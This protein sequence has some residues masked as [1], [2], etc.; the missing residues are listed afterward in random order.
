MKTFAFFLQH[1]FFIFGSI[2]WYY[3]PTHFQTS[4]FFIF[5][6]MFCYKKIVTINIIII[7]IVYVIAIIFIHEIVIVIAHVTTVV[8]GQ[9]RHFLAK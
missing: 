5:D 4:I 1:L 9:V 6:Y 7:V 8:W 2:F 3:I